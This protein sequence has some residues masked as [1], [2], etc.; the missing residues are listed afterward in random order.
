MSGIEHSFFDRH[1]E[2]IIGAGTALVA[3]MSAVIIYIAHRQWKQNEHGSRLDSHDKRFEELEKQL[4]KEV[5]EIKTMVKEEV[6]KAERDHSK[7]NAKVEQI[8]QSQQETRETLAKLMGKL[9]Q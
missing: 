2:S 6:A 7:I 4:L 8:Q 3:G 9:E 1:F 5:Q